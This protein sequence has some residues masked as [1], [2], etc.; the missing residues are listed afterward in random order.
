M[1]HSQRFE[2]EREEDHADAIVDQ[3]FAGDRRFH[4]LRHMGRLEDP[5]DSDRIGGGDQGPEQEA[6]DPRQLEPEEAEQPVAAHADEER[7]QGRANQRQNPDRP[8]QPPQ[9]REVNVK[10]AREKEHR[11]HPLH[12]DVGEIDR[13][14][15]RPLLLPRCRHPHPLEPHDAERR[16]QRNRHHAD[17]GGQPEH[18][19]VEPG[20]AGSEDEDDGGDIEHRSIVLRGGLIHGTVLGLTVPGIAIGTPLP[21]AEKSSGREGGE[22]RRGGRREDHGPRD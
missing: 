1:P 9:P 20:S 6:M 11:Q 2:K 13:L 14:E 15:Q 4:I 16:H 12:E 21:P 5:E 19:A 8:C 22:D 17:R 3:R 10:G 7:R 18:L